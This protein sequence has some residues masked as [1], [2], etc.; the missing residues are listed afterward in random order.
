MESHVLNIPLDV[1]KTIM[2]FCVGVEYLNFR[3]TCKQCHLAAP[4]IQ[5]SKGGRLQSYSVVLP[6]LMVVHKG[7]DDISFTDPMFGDKYFIKTPQELIGDLEID[8]SVGGWLL[9]RRIPGPL[10][11]FN[12]FTGDIRELPTV[13]YLQSYCFSA[14]PTSS[15]CMVVGFTALGECHMHIHFVAQE[16]SW[17][18]FHLNFCGDESFRFATHYGQNLYEVY[19]N[20]GLGFID[21]GNQDYSLL[22][23]PKNSCV[24]PKQNFLMKC[25]K[26]LL[27]VIV[28]LFGE[29]VEVFK[30]NDSRQWEKTETLG[31]HAIYIGGK[32]CLCIETKT[33][34]MA[35]KIYFPCVHPESRKIVFYSLETRRYHTSNTEEGDVAASLVSGYKLLDWAQECGDPCLPVAWLWL[36]CSL[37]REP[38]II[39]E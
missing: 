16:S 20:G 35:N 34:A 12:P 26:H 10:M 36:E 23:G 13:P 29:S 19:N 5:W 25:D 24:S 32:T 6:W 38:K 27:L 8:C 3:A 7:Q 15:D 39:S 11:F 21:A 9:V 17:F 2:K 14:P 33:P 4:M 18:E 1:L 31:R 30:M 37:D 22:N 28:G